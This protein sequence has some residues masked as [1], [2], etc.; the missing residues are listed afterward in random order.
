[1]FGRISEQDTAVSTVVGEKAQEKDTH[2]RSKRASSKDV[3]TPFKER[4]AK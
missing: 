2:A 4:L 1:V 3:T